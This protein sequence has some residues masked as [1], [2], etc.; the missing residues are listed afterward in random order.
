[1]RS[2]FSGKLLHGMWICALRASLIEM[3]IYNVPRVNS[4][5]YA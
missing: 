1:M 5:E 2:H 4:I 3:T